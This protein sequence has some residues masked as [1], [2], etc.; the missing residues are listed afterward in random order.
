MFRIVCLLIGY[1]IGCIETAYFVGKLWKTDLRRYGSGN[2]GTTNALRVLGKKAGALTFVGD[3]LKSLVA[4]FLC[5]AVF[6]EAPLAGVYGGV[7]AILG[8]DFPFY[9]HFRGGKGIAATIGLTLSIVLTMEPRLAIPTTVFGVC[10]VI[11]TRMISVGSL[12]LSLTIPVSC[13]VLDLPLELVVL[14]ALLC[15]LAFW[16]HKENIRR[17]LAGNENTFS[18]KKK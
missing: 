14:T 9:L 3:I 1:G 15:V 13:Y 4:F 7:G 6:P 16:R 17:I 10:A 5:R 18:L 2:L 12:V 11:L 8:H